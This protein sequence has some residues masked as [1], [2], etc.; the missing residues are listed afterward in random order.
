[1]N[2]ECIF[3]SANYGSCGPA[4]TLCYEYD[5]YF[6]VTNGEYE[7]Q[8]NFCPWCGMKATKQAGV[9]SE[10]LGRRVRDDHA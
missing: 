9:D 2:H 1:M 3:N 7:S 5:G 6:F 10:D 8:V 4:I